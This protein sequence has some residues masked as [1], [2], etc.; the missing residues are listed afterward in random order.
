MELKEAVQNILIKYMPEQKRH[1]KE[2]CEMALKHNV[3]I[4][5]SNHIYFSLYRLDKALERGEFNG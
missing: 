4:Y 5:E 2:A 1:F 3:D